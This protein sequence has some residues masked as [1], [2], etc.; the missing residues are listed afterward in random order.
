MSSNSPASHNEVPSLKGI[1][2]KNIDSLRRIWHTHTALLSTGTA[3][4]QAN[5]DED[6]PR[7][8]LLAMRPHQP[9]SRTTDYG[10]VTVLPLALKDKSQ[11]WILISKDSVKPQIPLLNSH[12]NSLYI[13]EL[14]N[15][16]LSFGLLTYYGD[17]KVAGKPEPLQDKKLSNST[18]DLA[19]YLPKPT[20]G[21][22]RMIGH[23]LGRRKAPFRRV[24]G[25]QN[26]C[27]VMQ[28][29]LH[30]APTRGY[31]ETELL[32][33]KTW[34]NLRSCKE[35]CLYIFTYLYSSTSYRQIYAITAYLPV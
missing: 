1:I 19:A 7:R 27:R 14:P 16:I 2:Y 8:N 31:W 18:S 3:S 25:L 20:L 22:A 11:C 29:A 24:K 33:Y 28:T 21:P 10:R 35:G 34:Q 30:P 5:D 6:M 26:H 13:A 12:L 4:S 17:Y 32:K 23:V 15:E 9:Q